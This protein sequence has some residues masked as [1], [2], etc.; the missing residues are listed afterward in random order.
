LDGPDFL[1]IFLVLSKFNLMT[2]QFKLFC[3]V[4]LMFPIMSVYGNPA[5]SS[6]VA[7]KTFKNPLLTSGPDPW[8]LAKDGVYYY[9]HTTGRN[10]T[11]WKTKNLEDIAEAEKTVAWV[12]PASGMNSKE[13]W[14]PE[15]HFLRGKWY[16][17]V[18]ADDGKN[19]NHRMW[20][21]ENPDKDPLSQNWTLKGK[22]SDPSDRWAI[23]M[24]VFEIKGQLYA[25]W[26]GWEGAVNVS[27]N[28]YLARLKNPWT[29]DG[30]RVLISKPELDWEKTGSGNGLPVVNE[31]PQFLRQSDKSKKVFVV[32]SASGCWTDNYALGLLEA[33]AGSDLMKPSSW[34]KS[35]VPVFQKNPEGK[36]FGPGHNSFFK[37]K[38]GKEDWIIYHANPEANQ[39]CRDKR[40]PRMQKFGWSKDGI[41]QFG[42]P[43]SLDE[44]IEV[45]SGN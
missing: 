14:A 33:E 12:P 27:Q 19:D 18:A 8:V 3:R 31:G 34:K 25:M 16:I 2:S 10:V 13:L 6:G 24:S 21:L 44:E 26:S 45:P 11:L 1:I 4:L 36:A 7:K 37:S 22:I 17:Y 28:I 20:V 39:G 38:D 29:V 40:S 42:K 30:E 32:Y 5:D 41:P 43:V 15:L 23:D 35:P 9:C